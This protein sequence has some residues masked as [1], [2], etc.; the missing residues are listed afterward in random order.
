[1][2]QATDVKPLVAV[3]TYLDEDA[4]CE[5]YQVIKGN[6]LIPSGLTQLNNLSFRYLHGCGLFS[7]SLAVNNF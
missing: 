2:T 3:A 1:M 4:G 7:S 6:L 5:V